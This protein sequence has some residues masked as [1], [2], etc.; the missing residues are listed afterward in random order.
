MTWNLGL[1]FAMPIVGHARWHAYRE[2][3]A[4]NEE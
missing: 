3:V 2:V 4:K 1:I